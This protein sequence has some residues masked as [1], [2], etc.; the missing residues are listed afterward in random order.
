M[1]WEYS[2]RSYCLQGCIKR[3]ISN[4]R[5]EY[6]FFPSFFLCLLPVPLHPG[7]WRWVFIWQRNTEM[8]KEK[9]GSSSETWIP[10]LG[11][12]SS[13]APLVT[14]FPFSLC[15]NEQATRDWK[16]WLLPDLSQWKFI[17]K[18]HEF[19]ILTFQDGYHCIPFFFSDFIC[20]L[21]IGK[22][23]GADMTFQWAIII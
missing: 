3:K 7:I 11:W 14:V 20:T 9:P 21:A 17:S 22:K 18:I 1:L 13:M 16:T 8:C 4:I 15:L 5:V 23:R 10:P 12:L 2:E 6:G 19:W